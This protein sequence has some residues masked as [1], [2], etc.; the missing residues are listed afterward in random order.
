M[1]SRGQWFWYALGLLLLALPGSFT[2]KSR[3]Y[4]FGILGL[5]WLLIV[6]FLKHARYAPP[7][8]ALL[9]LVTSNAAFWLSYLLWRLRPRMMGPL[10]VEGT[11]S[12]GVALSIWLAVLLICTLYEGFVF[13]RGVGTAQQRQVSVLGLVGLMLQVTTTLRVIYLLLQGV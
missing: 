11:D 10:G 4:F 2:T 12:F 8:T 13:L 9:L 6:L 3:P 7:G 5:G 1:T